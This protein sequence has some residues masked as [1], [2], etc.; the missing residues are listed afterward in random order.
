MPLTIA[1]EGR[2]TGDYQDAN[3]EIVDSVIWQVYYR[4]VGAVGI[5]I[6]VKDSY[7]AAQWLAANG[8]GGTVSWLVPGRLFV[9]LGI[10]VTPG[11]PN[12]PQMGALFAGSGLANLDTGIIRVG[13]WA[14]IL[15]RRLVGGASRLGVG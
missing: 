11:E 8:R 13:F 12:S 5:H 15:W 14:P 1:T 6:G 9:W 10:N 4:T 3:Q 2:V 7:P